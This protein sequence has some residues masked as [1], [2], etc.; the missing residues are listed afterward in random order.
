MKAYKDN[1]VDAATAN[2]GVTYRLAV[3]T[4]GNA[5]TV[6]APAAPAS[7]PEGKEFAGWR[8]FEGTAP[9]LTEKIYQ[10]GDSISVSENTSLNAVWKLQTPS[11]KLNLNGG[12]GVSDVNSVTYGQKLSI[13]ENPTRE[14]YSFEGWT[15]GKTVTENGFF[16]QRCTI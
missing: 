6:A 7:A 4:N 16:C 3:V 9:N 2:D 1:A 5:A 15:V 11:I 8:G 13:S 10:P 14:G 12:I